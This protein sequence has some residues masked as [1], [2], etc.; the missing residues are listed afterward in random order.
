MN[1]IILCYSNYTYTGMKVNLYLQE[2]IIIQNTNPEH[3]LSMYQAQVGYEPM[4][5]QITHSQGKKKIKNDACN[6]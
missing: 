1:D 4:L 3:I 2:A 5:E 6:Y